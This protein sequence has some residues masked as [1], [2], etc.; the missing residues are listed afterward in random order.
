MNNARHSLKQRVF[1]LKA[2]SNKVRRARR[3]KSS[4][5]AVNVNFSFSYVKYNSKCDNKCTMAKMAKKK[6]GKA[7]PKK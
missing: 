3:D 7:K 1:P 2:T 4:Y 5:G 6:K